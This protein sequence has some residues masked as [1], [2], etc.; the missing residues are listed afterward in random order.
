M[1]SRCLH[2]K[3]ARCSY[4]TTPLIHRRHRQLLDRCCQ[5]DSHCRLRKLITRTSIFP[6][7]A[8]PLSLPCHPLCHFS[9]SLLS[10]TSVSSYALHP[11]IRRLGAEGQSGGLEGAS[12]RHDPIHDGRQLL[13]AVMSLLLQSSTPCTPPPPRTYLCFTR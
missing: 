11:Q 3:R 2:A 10:A 1:P 7:E 5:K 12:E 6:S 4:P 8:R 9:A 13:H